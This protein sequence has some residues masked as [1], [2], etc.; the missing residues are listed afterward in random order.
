M[1]K[2]HSQ[3]KCWLPALFCKNVFCPQLET[4]F[5]SLKTHFF[6]ERYIVAGAFLYGK[7]SNAKIDLASL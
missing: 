3:K 4:L 2:Y 5:L 1:A 7:I 6:I